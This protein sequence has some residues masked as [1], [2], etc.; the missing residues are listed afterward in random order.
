MPMSAMTTCVTSDAVERL[1]S[2][3][4]VGELLGINEQTVKRYLREG[5]IR[6]VRLT[7]GTWRIRESDYRAYVEQCAK[8]GERARDD[9]D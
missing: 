5:I 6:G 2:P 1:L 8:D 3:K 9:H 7:S 4:E